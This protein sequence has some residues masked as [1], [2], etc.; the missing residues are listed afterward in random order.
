MNK[1]RLI[2]SISI[3]LVVAILGGLYYVNQTSE[4]E[5][6]EEDQGIEQ[7]ENIET[8]LL[9]VEGFVEEALEI[10]VACYNINPNKTATDGSEGIQEDERKCSKADDLAE[11]MRSFTSDP[12]LSEIEQ[13]L[14]VFADI[15]E[16]FSFLVDAQ[17]ERWNLEGED[18]GDRFLATYSDILE[19]ISDIR[20]EHEFNDA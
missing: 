11:E 19:Y 18:F 2:L 8:Q 9:T 3:I 12:E 20:Q 16:D 5:A 13:E 15:I 10:Y 4:H 1:K 14:L 6:I 17:P 7:G